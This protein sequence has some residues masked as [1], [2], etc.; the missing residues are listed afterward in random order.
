MRIRPKAKTV[1]LKSIQ[2]YLEARVDEVQKI[3]SEGH[4]WGFLASCTLL[5]FCA[6]LA[7][8]KSATKTEFKNFC[9]DYL[10]KTRQEYSAAIYQPRLSQTHPILLSNQIYHVLRCGITH[11]FSLTPNPPPNINPNFNPVA[12]SIILAHRN[13]NLT[14]LAHVE[15][16]NGLDAFILISEE[17]SLDIATTIKLMFQAARKKNLTGKALSNNILNYF[18]KFPPIGWTEFLITKK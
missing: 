3:A 11:G 10:F 17:F 18:K 15:Y 12:R 7:N 13:S 1:N 4:P 5:D 9:I 6:S 8:N 14:H 16:T 2:R